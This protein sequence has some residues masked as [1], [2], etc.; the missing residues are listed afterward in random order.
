MLARPRLE[1]ARMTETLPLPDADAR[2]HSARLEALIREEIAAHGGAI[3]F[4]RFMELALYAPV[5]LFFL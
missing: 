1:R 4:A 5:L 3:P 2:A